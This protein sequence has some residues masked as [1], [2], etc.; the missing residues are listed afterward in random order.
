MT[1][2]EYKLHFDRI[3]ERVEKARLRVNDHHIVKIVAA[4]KGPSER[5]KYK[6]SSQK[7][8]L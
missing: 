7:A 2:L 8:N 6:T 1:A 3:I 4:S 5:T